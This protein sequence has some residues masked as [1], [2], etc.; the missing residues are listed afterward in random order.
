MHFRKIYFNHSHLLRITVQDAL[1]LLSHF[2]KMLAQGNHI[3]Y[4]RDILLQL[5]AISYLQLE[6]ENS[7]K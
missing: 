7:F 4:V 6:T 2:L 5:C 3:Q 1:D